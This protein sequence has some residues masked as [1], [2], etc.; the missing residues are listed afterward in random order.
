MRWSVPTGATVVVALAALAM[1]PAAV[2][3]NQNDTVLVTK[4]G[5]V[6][7]KA[8]SD[9]IRGRGIE[10]SADAALGAGYTPCRICFAKEIAAVYDTAPAL[11]GGAAL[12]GLTGDSMA[13]EALSTVTQPF[14]FRIA[15]NRFSSRRR[16]GIPNPY[17]DLITV[18]P[19][20]AEQGAYETR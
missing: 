18:I 12:A 1:L 13:A 6:F 5:V 2:A 7:H 17:D 8:G 10:K 11:P 9:D 16:D 19:G 4:P 14:G 15:T 3:D 20:R